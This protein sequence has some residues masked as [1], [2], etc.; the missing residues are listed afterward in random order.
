MK[1]RKSE[2]MEYSQ[3]SE[4]ICH[5]KVQSPTFSEVEVPC[6]SVNGKKLEYFTHTSQSLIVT[7]K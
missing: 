1:E 5:F 3:Q 4:V 2:H 7:T 6:V